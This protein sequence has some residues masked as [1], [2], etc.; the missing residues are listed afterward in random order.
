MIKLY[1]LSLSSYC[2]KVRIVLRIKGVAFEEVAPPGGHYS[3]AEYQAYLP[4][5]SIPAIEQ[6]SFKLYDSEAIVEYLEDI[7]DTPCMRAP[8]LR[9]RAR[10]RALAQFHNSALE[11]TVRASFPLARMQ[12]GDIDL[13]DL[14][15]AY[16]KFTSSLDKLDGLIQANPFIGGKE[17]CLADCGFPATIRMGQDIFAHLGKNTDFS[18]NIKPWLK[19]LEDHSIIGDE[20]EKNRTAICSWLESLSNE[21]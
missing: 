17:P 8:D 18:G 14:D 1:A 16:S 11:P 13:V 2:T 21:K 12:A 4:P 3:S 6:D 9:E 10:Q 15:N 7:S 5:G 19:A 20:V